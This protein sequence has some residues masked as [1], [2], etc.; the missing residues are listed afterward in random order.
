MSKLVYRPIVIGDH[1]NELV[2]NVITMG[3]GGHTTEIVDHHIHEGRGSLL[4]QHM[5]KEVTHKSSKLSHSGS[6]LYHVLIDQS[7]TQYCKI[8]VL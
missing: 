7:Y 5:L 2:D 6:W 3:P 1:T 4:S 8:L